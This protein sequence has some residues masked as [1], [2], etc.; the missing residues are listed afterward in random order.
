ML[1]ANDSL[2]DEEA[3]AEELGLDGGGP[4]SVTTENLLASV[5]TLRTWAAEAPQMSIA[6]IDAIAREIATYSHYVRSCLT[7]LVKDWMRDL[8]GRIEPPP[9]P[10]EM[11]PAAVASHMGSS[12]TPFMRSVTLLGGAAMYGQ[13]GIA[14]A[15]DL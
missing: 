8:I 2:E 3:D 11:G 10:H 13:A 15:V 1:H 6:D 14:E 7:P 5:A 9:P 12:F 4:G